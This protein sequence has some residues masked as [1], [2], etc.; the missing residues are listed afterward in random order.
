MSCMCVESVFFMSGCSA[1][2]LV[3]VQFANKKSMLVGDPE[4]QGKPIVR[5]ADASKKLEAKLADQQ[6]KASL[7]GNHKQS[8]PSVPPAA[9]VSQRRR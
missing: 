5:K 6:S 2:T 9:N 3:Y 8:V 4:G 7:N 1:R